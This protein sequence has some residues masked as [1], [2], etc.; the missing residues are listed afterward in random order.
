MAGR[1]PGAEDRHQRRPDPGAADRHL[2][3]RRPHLQVGRLGAE[4]DPRAHGDRPRVRRR[5]R[6][7][8][9]RTSPT[10]SP[11]ISSAAKA[12]WSAAAAATAWPAAGISAP[13]RQ[14]RR[15]ESPGRVRRVHRA[16]DDQH[17]ACTRDGVDRDVAGDLRSVRQRRPHG[18]LVPGA[19]R[20]RADHRRRPD[21]HHG[22]GGR[23]RT[24]AR[25][26]S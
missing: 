25:A 7:S 20:R 16:A 3:H 11:A 10:S 1:R 23:A 18:A 15:R 13:R 8:R 12:T 21:R 5:D 14:G 9:A 19:R 4:D 17:L 2:R 24:P 6:R 26:T 22:R